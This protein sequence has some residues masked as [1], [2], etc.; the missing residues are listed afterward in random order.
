MRLLL[1]LL[2]LILLTTLSAGIPAYWITRDQLERQTWAQVDNARKVTQSL[3]LAEQQRLENLSLLFV[4]RPTLQRLAQ[5]GAPNELQQYMRDFQRQSQLDILLF[6]GVDD[7][8]ISGSEVSLGCPQVKSSGFVLLDDRPAMLAEQ[9]VDEDASGQLLGRT[10]AG[11]WLEEPFLQRLSSDTSV[12]Q[13]ILSPRGARLASSLPVITTLPGELPGDGASLPSR[14]VLEID[15][16]R[17]YASYAPVMA[18]DGETVFYSE[19]ALPVDDL[20]ATENSALLVL[21]TSTG[22]VA[23]LGALLGIWTMRQ[24]FAP[25]QRL[26]SAAEQIG[27]GDLMVPIPLIS[28]PIE[29]NTLATALHK[30]QASMLQA[31][32]ERSAARDWLDALIQSIV[33]GVVTLDE[34]GSITFL[35]QGAE[36]LIGWDRDQALGKHANEIFRL[37]DESEGSFLD[38]IPPPDGKCLISVVTRAGKSVVLAVTRA[39]LSPPGGESAQVALVLRDVT[40]EEAVRNLRSYFLANISH[41]FRTPLSTLI[42]SMEMLLNPA[43]AFSPSEVQELLKPSYLSLRMLQNLIDNLL[44]SSSIEAGRFNINRR[45]MAV[46][47]ILENAMDVA[48]PLLERRGQLVTINVPTSLPELEVDPARTTLALINLLTNASKYSPPGQPIEVSVEQQDARVRF[49]V[50]DRGSG[51][52]PGERSNLFRR[53]VRLGAAEGEQYGIGLGLYVV[54]STVEAHGGSVGVE[55]RPGG[56]SMFWFELPLRTGDQE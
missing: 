31:L 3:L 2:V 51:I 29:V 16:G 26:T 28:S 40:Q 11:I 38:R 22:I 9:P 35:S 32:Q 15:G 27:R 17:Y 37:S 10:V 25:L 41:E 44:E 49:A 14:N 23:A 18:S 45:P 43:E 34:Q 42:A 13:T 46:D 39:S 48:G 47:K 52:S 54:K 55:S 21:A 8:L 12:Q 36:T 5:E 53:F 50:A 56:G 19:V 30:S 7:Q 24:L 1:G 20:I 33:E 4:E 6:C